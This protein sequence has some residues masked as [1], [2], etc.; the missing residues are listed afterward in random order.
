MPKIAVALVSF[1]VF[2]AFPTPIL[3]ESSIVINEFVSNVSSPEKEW[4]EFYN[5]GSTD[6]SLSGWFLEERTGSDLSGTSSHSLDSI[7][8][9]SHSYATYEFSSSS[10]NNDGDILTLKNGATQI[11]EIAYGSATNSKI[12]APDKGQSG[13]RISDGS[14]QWVVFSSSTKGSTNNT[15]TVVPSPT[16]TPS[17]SPT[18]NTTSTTSTS[19]PT[20]I[21]KSS[22]TTTTAKSPSPKSVSSP[23]VLGESQTDSTSQSLLDTQQS[24]PSPSSS[25]QAT[26]LSKTRVAGML[27]GSGIMLLGLSIGFYLWYKRI[28]GKSEKGQ[29]ES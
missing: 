8:I 22:S 9:P 18:P 3:G 20:P 25:P 5:S 24:S 1:V 21:P 23:A 6:Q 29:N 19:T 16:P 2:L 27:V 14:D 26:S 11:D 28:L 15:A 4:V 13:G 17:P 7:T 10:L 12:E